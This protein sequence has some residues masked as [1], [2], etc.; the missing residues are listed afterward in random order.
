MNTTQVQVRIPDDVLK[1][2][3][4]EAERQQRSRS[5][6]ILVILTQWTVKGEKSS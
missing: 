4:E 3:D 1:E 6:M 2:I 5:N